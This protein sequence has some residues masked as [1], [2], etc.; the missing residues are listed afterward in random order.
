MCSVIKTVII[1]AVKHLKVTKM[2]NDVTNSSMQHKMSMAYLRI[3]T[4]NNAYSFINCH[5][6]IRM[7]ILKTFSRLSMLLITDKTNTNSYQAWILVNFTNVGQRSMNLV[8]ICYFYLVNMIS[9]EPL[10][11]FLLYLAQRC[12]MTSR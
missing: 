10:G 6:T 5:Q 7:I 12:I 2:L 4:H 3:Y 1:N 8:K 9:Q 11:G